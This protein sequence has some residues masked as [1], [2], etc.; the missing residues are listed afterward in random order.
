MATKK[1]TVT[2][3]KLATK[4]AKKAVKKATKK[5]GAKKLT[6]KAAKKTV[7]KVSKVTLKLNLKTKTA[8]TAEEIQ[9]AAY[10]NYV[11]RIQSGLSGSPEHDWAKAEQDLT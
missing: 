4:T 9:Q 6:K 8:P 11:E 3:K 7:K 5:A 10:F 2:T 1:T